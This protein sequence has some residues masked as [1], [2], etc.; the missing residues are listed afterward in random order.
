[1]A[2]VRQD[3]RKLFARRAHKLGL[4]LSAWMRMSLLEQAKAR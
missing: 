2:R 4:S 1:M 3:E